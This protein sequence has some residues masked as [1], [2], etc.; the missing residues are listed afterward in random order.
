L[1]QLFLELSG[2]QQ[3]FAAKHFKALSS[4]QA[5]CIYE[6]LAAEILMVVDFYS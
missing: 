6:L 3:C 5:F 2:Y 1:H 4:Y